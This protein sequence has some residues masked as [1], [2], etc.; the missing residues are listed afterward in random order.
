MRFAQLAIGALIAAVGLIAFAS[1]IFDVAP[2]GHLQF[3][4]GF[5]LLALGG[6]IAI[7]PLQDLLGEEAFE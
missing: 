2:L 6:G 5:V 7:D 1:A 3:A 4:G